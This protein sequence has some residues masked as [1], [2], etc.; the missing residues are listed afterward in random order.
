MFALQCETASELVLTPQIPKNEAGFVVL[1]SKPGDYAFNP[2]QDAT[3]S[4]SL[5]M[6]G[7]WH[8]VCHLNNQF[9]YQNM[10]VEDLGHA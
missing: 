6:S 5:V 3:H 9:V 7:S 8:F 2:R 10:R 1:V 4:V